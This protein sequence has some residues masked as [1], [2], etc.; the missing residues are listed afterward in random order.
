[1]AKQSAQRP[2]GPFVYLSVLAGFGLAMWAVKPFWES[3]G[4]DSVRAEC[5]VNLELIAAREASIAA[6]EGRPLACAAWPEA[7]PG[8]EGTPWNEIPV[9]WQRLGFEPGLI[10]HGRY[11]ATTSPTGWTATCTVRV[12]E[13]VETWQATDALTAQRISP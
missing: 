3:A 4:H 11:E 6:E 2:T 12:G 7:P 1:M 9:C 10:L 8:A 13:V 5:I